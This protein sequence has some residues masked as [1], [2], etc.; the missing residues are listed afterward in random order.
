MKDT[1][2]CQNM[3][4]NQ[5]TRRNFILTKKI[6]QIVKLCRLFSRHAKTVGSHR[7]TAISKFRLFSRHAEVD[8]R[9]GDV[10][11]RPFCAAGW[12][13]RAARTRCLSSSRRLQVKHKVAFRSMRG[14]AFGKRRMTT[15]RNLILNH[16]PK[17][18]ILCHFSAVVCGV[19]IGRGLRSG[20]PRTS[21]FVALPFCDQ[22]G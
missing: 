20:A 12:G 10:A 8:T 22:T 16:A 7:V 14:C 2:D 15:H 3:P 4:I 21:P 17:A 13:A 1:A 19:T 9:S 5:S 11:E 6:R 18:A